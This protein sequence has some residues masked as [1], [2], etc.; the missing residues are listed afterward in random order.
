MLIFNILWRRQ[1]QRSLPALTPAFFRLG[2]S[3]FFTLGIL[4]LSY[5]SYVL[6]DAQR[7]QTEQAQRFEHELKEA[8]TTRA[9]RLA[10]PVR[11]GAPLGRIKINRV[12]LTALVQEGIDEGT[13][14]RAVGHIPGTSLPGQ[15]GNVGLAGHRDSFFRELRHI[16]LD[17][18]ITLET[19]NGIY[20]Y[21]VETTRV[22]APEETEVLV[23][24]GL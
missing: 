22:V 8:P 14:R 6:L 11:E 21:R 1:W 13:L 18:E 24:T 7:Y 23:D 4:A 19:L 5:V 10:S 20:R 3:I 17:D 15:P 9:E 16:R 12:G 2:R